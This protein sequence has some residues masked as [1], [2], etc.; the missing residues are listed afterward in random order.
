MINNDEYLKYIE[1]HNDLTSCQ[2]KIF[3]KFNEQLNT[4]YT[5]DIARSKFHTVIITSEKKNVISITAKI[6]IILA[7]FFGITNSRK[8]YSY[9][10]NNADDVAVLEYMEKLLNSLK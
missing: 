3:N 6:N 2:K 5:R 4:L 7:K 10:R 9:I 1:K 8:I